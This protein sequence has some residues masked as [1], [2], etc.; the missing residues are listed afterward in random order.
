MA[1][2]W[3]KVGEDVLKLAQQIFLPRAQELGADGK[4]FL[5]ETQER[6]IKYRLQLSR[7]EISQAEYDDLM[8]DVKAL[9]KLEKYKQQGLTQAALDQFLNGAIDILFKAAGVAI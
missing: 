4:K 2:E 9:A 7:G 8:L 6:L 3:N 1:I 5:Q